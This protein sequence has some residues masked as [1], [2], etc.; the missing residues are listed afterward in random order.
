[1]A[2][3]WAPMRTKQKHGWAD[4]SIRSQSEQGWNDQGSIRH[5][6]VKSVT[7][8]S[9]GKANFIATSRMYSQANLDII[10]NVHEC[11]ERHEAKRA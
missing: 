5:R 9:S 3:E 6:H 2:G 1:M 7:R 11:I 8:G 10:Q 4:L